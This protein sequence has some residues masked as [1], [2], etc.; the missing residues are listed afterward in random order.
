M[1][2][3]ETA[4]LLLPPSASADLVCPVRTSTCV[5]ADEAEGVIK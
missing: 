1:S 5:S 2:E 3:N 4:T